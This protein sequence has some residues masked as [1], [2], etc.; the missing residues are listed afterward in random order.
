VGRRH[1][2]VASAAAIGATERFDV[3]GQ[4]AAVLW[5]DRVGAENAICRVDL[6]LGNGT[7]GP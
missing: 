5:P 3:D 7:G 2:D 1:S 6:R 4:A